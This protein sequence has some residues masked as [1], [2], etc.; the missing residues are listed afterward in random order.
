MKK[1]YRVPRIGDG[2]KG[3]AYKPDVEDGR[4]YRVVAYHHGDEEVEVEFVDGS[5]LRLDMAEMRDG[6]GLVPG[7]SPGEDVEVG[8]KRAYNG[9]VYACQQP[10]TTQSDWTPPETP[11]LWGRTQGAVPDLVERV[12]ALADIRD[13]VGEDAQAIIDVLLGE[14]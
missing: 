13:D 8:D 5:D 12:A 2:S 11:A 6:L 10:H 4:D 3:N 14:G 9:W 1:T 7:W